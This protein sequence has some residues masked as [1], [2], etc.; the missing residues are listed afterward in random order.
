MA[1]GVVDFSPLQ[2]ALAGYSR[3]LEREGQHL[4]QVAIGNALAGPGGTKAAMDIAARRGDL[5]TRLQ[6]DTHAMRQRGEARE[7][8]TFQDNR[9]K[10]LDTQFGKI[11]E[12]YRAE[13][14]PA[15]RQ[16]QWE[17]VQK[18]ISSD[19]RLSGAYKGLL[20]KMPEFKDPD[21]LAQYWIAVAAPHRDEL[22]RRQIEA[23]IKKDEASATYD[24]ARATAAGNKTAGYDNLNQYANTA[25]GMRKEFQALPNVKGYE[26]ARGAAD[27]LERLVTASKD[28]K[29]GTGAGDIAMVFNYMKTLDPKSIVMP[30]EAASA[31]NAPG[32]TENFRNYYNYLLSGQF[33]TPA[34]RNDFLN[35][36]NSELASRKGIAVQEGKRYRGLARGVSV[37]P[38][39][40]VPR[41]YG[42]IDLD[43]DGRPDTAGQQPQRFDAPPRSTQPQRPGQSGARPLSPDNHAAA[44]AEANAALQAGAPRGAILSACAN[45]VSTSKKPTPTGAALDHAKWATSTTSFPKRQRPARAACS[46]TSFRRPLRDRARSLILPLPPP[47]GRQRTHPMSIGCCCRVVMTAKLP[48]LSKPRPSCAIT[49][50]TSSAR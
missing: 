45:W 19:P 11:G 44:I 2:N 49:L 40:I 28:G 22:T 20:Q 4:D 16:A 21:L 9:Q 32:V 41:M 43:G 33:L 3:G 36:V 30:G 29:F 8:Q 34:T 42:G 48:L 23:G 10:I 6:L 37:N 18:I 13:T 38:D 12:M 26:Q 5:S 7:E 14:D 15:K 25:E 39:H 31:R 17:T 27:R 50:A 35:V 24:T 47:V 1:S 46:T